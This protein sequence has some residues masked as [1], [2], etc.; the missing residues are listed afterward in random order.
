MESTGSFDKLRQGRYDEGSA[1]GFVQECEDVKGCIY[2]VCSPHNAAWGGQFY[3]D[4]INF[5]N[6]NS[7]AEDVGE[8]ICEDPQ[9]AWDLYGYEC[10]GEYVKKTGTINILGRDVKIINLVSFI[11]FVII[12][13]LIAKKSG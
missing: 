6:K 10:D 8:F 9:A 3:D 13:Y 5:C 4:C 2:R 11:V 12:L 7:D 1:C